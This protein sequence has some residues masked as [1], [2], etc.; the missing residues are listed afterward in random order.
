M[1]EPH[2]GASQIW[3][4]ENGYRPVKSQIRDWGTNKEKRV[5]ALEAQAF[6]SD[7]VYAD[8]ASGLAATSEG[9]QF[10]VVNAH[11]DYAFDV[12]R[13]DPRSVATLIASVPSVAVLSDLD[14]RLDTLEASAVFEPL[15][16]DFT[17]IGLAYVDAGDRVWAVYGASGKRLDGV[18]QQ[19]SELDPEF[20]LLAQG[21]AD[22]NDWVA[23]AVLA[24][25]LTDTDQLLAPGKTEVRERVIIRADWN[26][27]LG[28]GQSLASRYGDNLN[29]DVSKNG[30]TND[31]GHVHTFSGGEGFDLNLTEA[32]TAF[33][34]LVNDPDV[35]AAHGVYQAAMIQMDFMIH[36]S[37]AFDHDPDFDGVYQTVYSG[38]P[39]AGQSIEALSQGGATNARDTLVHQISEAVSI[40]LASGESYQVQS[41][42]WM[43]GEG[44]WQ[45]DAATYKAKFNALV[46]DLDAQVAS[47]VGQTKD[48]DILT[49][50]TSSL[51]Y[52]HTAG[53]L[54]PHGVNQA[55]FE[56][57][58]E[59]PRVVV[60]T[61]TY[62]V[63]HDDAYHP[64]AAANV[65]L[66]AQWGKVLYRRVFRGENWHP[67]M[68][69]MVSQSG[70][71]MVLV[72][73]HVPEGPLQWD[74]ATVADPGDYGFRVEDDSGFV[75]VSSVDIIG[76]DTVR[77]V[78]SA[79]IGANAKVSYAYYG[80]G[81]QGGGPVTG[82]RGCLKD[83]D[84][85][86]S[87]DGIQPLNN[88][89][90]SFILATNFV[91]PSRFTEGT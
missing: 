51:G 50:Q 19:V 65:W 36:G 6:S 87:K 56:L 42:S 44:N 84:A 28:G 76:P 24:S 11:A 49:F 66:G 67:L 68:P 32:G 23:D 4:D 60:A 85:T 40:A 38:K 22:G 5:A 12:F 3:R 33:T 8:T 91:A 17:Q 26:H 14:G 63:T 82:A 75:A 46:G 43:Q 20:T 47:L 25:G 58:L 10:K 53:E 88:W 7:P 31:T 86:V 9:D 73:F 69:V 48:F 64:G 18:D 78:T 55:F 61:P 13:H 80:T 52:P 39:Y 45:D 21:A 79:D 89:A 57:M 1:T 77:I 30:Y 54:H 72:K 35:A 59:N 74:T 83:S 15:D 90:V 62:F 71:R 34:S 2:G 27:H 41:L 16:P 70:P 81:G 37:A 29:E